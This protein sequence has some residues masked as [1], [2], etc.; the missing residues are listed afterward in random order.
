MT[1]TIQRW[2]RQRIVPK[3]R[4]QERVFEM[5]WSQREEGLVPSIEL[6]FKAAQRKRQIQALHANG[7]EFRSTENTSMLMIC[8]P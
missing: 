4:A 6:E 2:W 3:L 7:I 5:F 8:F 1:I